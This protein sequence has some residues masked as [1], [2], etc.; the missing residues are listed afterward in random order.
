MFF[1]GEKIG[2]F[3]NFFQLQVK[4]PAEMNVPD[5]E[6]KNPYRL[7]NN[8]R[9]W[10]TDGSNKDVPKPYT[11][12]SEAGAKILFFVPKKHKQKVNYY[13]NKLDDGWPESETVKY[14]IEI[15]YLHLFCVQD[16]RSSKHL[17]RY[18]KTKDM[19]YEI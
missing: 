1:W 6:E 16:M 8:I 4:A 3:T 2:A 11:S 10:Y 5:Y 15:V 9:T 14:Y 18:E 17:R 7:K 19:R 13:F 12:Y